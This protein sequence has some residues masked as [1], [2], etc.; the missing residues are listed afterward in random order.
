MAF[1]NVSSAPVDSVVTNGPSGG[2]QLLEP[3]STVF[4]IHAG[5]EPGGS[6]HQELLLHPAGPQPKLG[7]EV[8]SE[9]FTLYFCKCEDLIC[10][11]SR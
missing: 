3:S 8:I 6:S 10:Q 7:P 4:L 2:L 5:I 11:T 1:N 9:L